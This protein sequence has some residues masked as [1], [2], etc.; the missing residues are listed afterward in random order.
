M[1]KKHHWPSTSTMLRPIPG[2]GGISKEV[3]T[4]THPTHYQS[5]QSEQTPESSFPPSS[6]SMSSSHKE[7]QY[8]RHSVLRTTMHK[9]SQVV[10][11]KNKQWKRNLF[12]SKTHSQQLGGKC[13]PSA[14]IR[15]VWGKTKGKPEQANEIMGTECEGP[16]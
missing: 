12:C 9:D 3:P 10:F 4:T 8:R 15:R 14:A 7:L 1:T 13:Q 6:P 11:I 5:K 16:K 2:P